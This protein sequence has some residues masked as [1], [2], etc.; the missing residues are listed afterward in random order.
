MERINTFINIIS[1][2]NIELSNSNKLAKYFTLES[3][4]EEEVMKEHENKLNTSSCE[5]E[6]ILKALKQ[7][8]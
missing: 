8:Y 3:N 4:Y 6:G 5:G 2:I 7:I 1:L